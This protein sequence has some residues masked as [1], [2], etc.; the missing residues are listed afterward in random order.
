MLCRSG[1]TRNVMRVGSDDDRM[2]PGQASV[3]L[4]VHVTERLVVDGGAA[5]VSNLPRADR[6]TVSISPPHT[7]HA[8]ASARCHSHLP[9]GLTP[10]T[11][12]HNTNTH[13]S[14]SSH[15]ATM[16]PPHHMSSHSESSA[17]THPP[18][19]PAF[20]HTTPAR[21]R[22]SHMGV[23]AGKQAHNRHAPA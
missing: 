22:A 12:Q 9:T 7:T 19:H 11:S 1:V 23:W 17:A 15:L 20:L 2:S 10:H 3:L 13:I 16:P 18:T 21:P 4:H 6:L 5:P 14:I 8:S